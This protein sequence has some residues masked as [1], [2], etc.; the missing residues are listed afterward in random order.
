LPEIRQLLTGDAERLAAALALDKADARLEVQYLL[1][2]AL[3]KPRAWLLAH[4]E[5]VP[6][7][8]GLATYAKWL[9]RRLQGEPVAYII[10]KREFFGLKFRVTPATL[11]PRPETELLV[12]LALQY[13]AGQSPCRVLD[14]GTGSGAIALAIAHARPDVEVTAS[15]ASPEALAV[16]RE[17]ARLQGAGNVQFVQ[18]DW[19]D[20]VAAQRFDLVVSNPPYVAADDP[21]LHQGD[22]PF[23]PLSALVAGTDGLDDI[24]RIVSRAPDYL[25]P[26]GW[27]LLEH[28]Y[29]QAVQVRRLL[30]QAGLGEVF[31]ACDLAVIERVSGGRAA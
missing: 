12:E 17:N 10:G 29:D 19:F 6:D 11:I 1:Q 14:L 9:Q 21:H 3:H 25:Q 18:G 8:S 22:L 27:L 31:S 2:H 24:R 30:Q 20:G 4:Q 23:E 15:D 7:E 28:G 13:I 5:Q 16:A 26:G